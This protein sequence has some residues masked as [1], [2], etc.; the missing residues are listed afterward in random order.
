MTEAEDA[1]PNEDTQDPTAK[2]EDA[3]KKPV[4]P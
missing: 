2:P 4:L 3:E 1:P